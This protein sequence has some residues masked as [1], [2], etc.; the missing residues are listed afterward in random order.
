MLLLI[1]DRPLITRV[2]TERLPANGIFLYRAPFETA[3]FHFEKRDTGGIILDCVGASEDPYILCATLREQYSALPIAAIVP[4]NEVVELPA[5]MLL[6]DGNLDAI[7]DGA[8]EFCH[9][10][11]GWIEEPLRVYSLSVGSTPDS[12]YYMGYRLPLAPRAYEILR[13]LFY[14]MPRITSAD[15]LMDL[16]FPGGRQGIA[17]LSVQISNINRVASA[18][19]PRPLIVNEYGKGYRLRDGL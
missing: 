5:D 12:V 1:T 4:K 3:M 15:E 11:C 9:V 14:R 17:N 18:I 10:C 13:C 6:R 16:C 19:D 2:L 7:C 8:L